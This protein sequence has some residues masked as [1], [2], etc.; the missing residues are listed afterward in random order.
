M[1]AKQKG[2]VTISDRTLLILLEILEEMFQ[3]RHTFSYSLDD[4]PEDIL[5][6]SFLY[7]FTVTVLRRRLGG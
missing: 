2:K 6:G 1:Q 7:G 4:M 3:L 5:M